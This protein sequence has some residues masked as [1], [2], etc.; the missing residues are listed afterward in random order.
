MMKKYIIEAVYNGKRFKALEM[1]RC[2]G[3]AR[4]Q[5]FDKWGYDAYVF[6]IKEVKP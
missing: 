3:R 2:L 6:N 4:K 1:A 5:F